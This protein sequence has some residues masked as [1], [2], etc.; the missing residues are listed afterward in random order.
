MK[1]LVPGRRTR[2][3][4]DMTPRS[5]FHP[6]RRSEDED[7]TPFPGKRKSELPDPDELTGEVANIP[8]KDLSPA[9]TDEVPAVPGTDDDPTS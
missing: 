7:E 2:Y 6:H 4:G 8:G 5:E 1:T 3:A 9:G